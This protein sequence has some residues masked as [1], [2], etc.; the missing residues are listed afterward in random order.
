MDKFNIRQLEAFRATVV[1]GSVSAAAEALE[2]SQPTISRLVTSLEAS[3]GVVLFNRANGR[4]TPTPEGE[5]IFEQVEHTFLALTRIPELADDLKNTRI[6]NLTISCMPALG[7]SFM[8]SVISAFCKIY[9]EVSISLEVQSSVKVEDWIAAEHIDF[10]LA[11]LPY[12]RRDLSVDEFCNEPYLGV[13][14]KGHVLKEKK[15][16]APINFQ[17]ENFISMTPNCQ[18]RK[19]IDQLFDNHGVARKLKLETSYLPTVCSMVEEGLG[20]SLA[21]PFSI[22]AYSGK[23]EYRKMTPGLNFRVGIFF[24][25]HRP[26]SKMGRAFV[27]FMKSHRDQWISKV[28]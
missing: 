23:I 19:H 11:E 21:D 18:A 10:G 22:N 15:V 12:R 8:P 4:M 13:F 27:G 5:M 17:G 1:S 24:P 7:I 6:G 25:K 26:L 28:N 9:P 16:L 2:S 20:V 3:L 14:P